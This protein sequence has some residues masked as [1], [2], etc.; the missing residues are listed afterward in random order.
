[1][2]VKNEGQKW[3]SKIRDKNLS[4]Q[5]SQRSQASRIALCMAKVNVTDWL[6]EWVSEWVTRSPIELSWT[7]KKWDEQSI[8]QKWFSTK[9]IS[10]WRQLQI[11]WSNYHFLLQSKKLRRNPALLYGLFIDGPVFLRG[12]EKSMV[13]KQ[14]S[15]QIACETFS[16]QQDTF[17]SGHWVPPAKN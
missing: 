2:R 17:V 8:A 10:C 11:S 16:L 9:V 14:L 3:G 5:M 4:H 7:A 15:H 12:A 1:M 13:Q 6:S